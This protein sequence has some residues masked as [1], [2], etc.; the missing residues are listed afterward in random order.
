MVVTR[1]TP[2]LVKKLLGGEMLLLAGLITL[3][4]LGLIS[5]HAQLESLV[6]L[7][8]GALARVIAIKLYSDIADEYLNVRWSRMV[9][10]ALATNSV[11]LLVRGGLSND[12]VADWTGAYNHSPLRGFINHVFSVPATIFLLLGLLGMLQ[13]YRHTGLGRR[14]QGRDYA[15]IATL[16][17]LFGWLLIF[18]KNLE[19]GQ[20]PWI[21]NRILQPLDLTLIGAASIISIVLHRYT[22]VMQGGKMAIV[23]QWLVLY[24]ALPGLLVLLIQVGVPIIHRTIPFDATPLNHLWALLP[25]L[26]ALSAATRAEMTAKA[27]AQ[28]ARLKQA[29]AAG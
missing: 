28:V 1:L 11:M 16:L 19:E 21:I 17:V 6:G 10:L 3:A 23:L 7:A 22:A 24:G 2:G 9:W 8:F 15:V 26:T 29:E 12:F 20:S 5:R 25:W 13:S 18:H 4:K 27:V 14:L